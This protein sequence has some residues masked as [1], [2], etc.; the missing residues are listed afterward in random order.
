MGEKE[1]NNSD[2]RDAVRIHDSFP[3]KYNIITQ[4][5]Y[6]KKESLYISR[7]TINR[8]AGKRKEAEAFSFDW[9]SIEDEEDFDPV[10][11]KILFRLDQKIDIVLARQD[12]ILKKITSQDHEED[13]YETGECIDISGT[14][15]NMLISEDLSNETLLELN[16]EPHIHPAIQIIALGKITR[17]CPSRD[18]EKSGYEISVAFTAIN[19]DDREALIKYIFQRQHE[20]ISYRKRID[21]SSTT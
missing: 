3:I 19:E 15:V 7:R 17:V 2:N 9:S 14:G 20:L 1:K 12:E 13:I 6:D 11:V 4:K 21:S 18:K 8:S 10:L 16:I 5:E